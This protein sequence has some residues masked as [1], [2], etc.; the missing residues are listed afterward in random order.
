MVSTD[1]PKLHTY[2]PWNKKEIQKSG[3]SNFALS[4]NSLPNNMTDRLSSIS[5]YHNPQILKFCKILLLSTTTRKVPTNTKE[6]IRSGFNEDWKAHKRKWKEH[7]NHDNKKEG[8]PRKRN[9]QR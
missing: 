1:A 7:S 6:K 9:I 3:D 4:S 8:K 2:I 5:M